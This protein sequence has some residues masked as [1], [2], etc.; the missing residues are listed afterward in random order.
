MEVFTLGNTDINVPLLQKK[1]LDVA[2]TCAFLEL[3]TLAAQ[4]LGFFLVKK[5]FH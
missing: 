4:E 3:E 2:K 1:S 5:K